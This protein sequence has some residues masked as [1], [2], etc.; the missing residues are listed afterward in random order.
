MRKG[1]KNLRAEKIKCIICII[2]SAALIMV[3]LVSADVPKLQPVKYTDIA[4]SKYESQLTEWI[5]NGFVT[6]LNF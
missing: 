1:G 4:G 5:D 2:L 3:N 6:G